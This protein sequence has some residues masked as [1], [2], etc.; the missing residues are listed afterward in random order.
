MIGQCHD[1]THG[2]AEFAFLVE[3]GNAW[4]RF[5]DFA[6]QH[7]VVQVGT[8]RAAELLHEVAG[9]AGDVDQLADQVG[10]HSLG[11]VFQIQVEIIHPAGEFG[12]EVV[13][14]VLRAQVVQI[15]AGLDEGAA[16]LGH[17]GAVHG[18]KAVAV[19]GGGFAQPGAVQHGGPEQ[20]MEVDDVLADEMVQ[21]GGGVLAPVIVEAQAFAITIVLEA[22]HV[23][24]GGIQ[25]HVEIFAR[26]AGDLKAEVGGFTGD[27]PG[28]QVFD[29]FLQFVGYLLL[30][31]AGAGP[32]AQQG[33]ELGQVEEQ[34]GG[35][36]FHRGGTA[37]RRIGVDQL[38]RGIG[39]ATDFAVVAVLVFALALGAGALDEAIGQEHAFL[40]VVQL[41]NGLFQDV[42]GILVAL[43]NHFRQRPVLGAVSAVVVVEIH[44]EVGKV[45][46]VVRFHLGNLLL[47]GDAVF[48]G[49]EHDGGA[50]GIVSADIGAL[51]ATE[52]LEANPDVGLD[53]FQQ[54]AEMNGAIGVGKGTGD[55]YLAGSVT[56]GNGVVFQKMGG[57]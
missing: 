24:D 46:L 5:L 50:V 2:L 32:F 57:L 34:L 7:H 25:P 13:A 42:T 33:F 37:D 22:G 10:V 54:M 35:F 28:L 15:G 11:E 51:L 8:E 18:D 40:W 56:H 41:G 21:L 30:Q 9:A 3:I 39:G 44:L 12:G 29:P 19:D 14:Q 48:L 1:F 17:F 27:I 45:P 20:A 31:G 47:R 52:L 49:L 23:A 55:Q 4:A 26:V 36:L 53:V 16:G 38:C 6:H 43:E